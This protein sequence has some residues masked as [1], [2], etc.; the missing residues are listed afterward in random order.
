MTGGQPIDGSLSVEDLILQL[1]GEGVRR[2]ALVTDDPDQWRGQFRD[3][4]GYSLHHR[5]E[6]DAL[7]KAARISRHLGDRLPADLCRGEAPASQEGRDG[8]PGQIPVY[9]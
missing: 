7:Q 6:M 2:I 5:D 3:L 9:Q 4:T 8:R 1:R